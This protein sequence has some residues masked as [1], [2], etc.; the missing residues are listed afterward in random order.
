MRYFYNKFFGVS[1]M[2]D[3][4]E[5]SVDE[6][7]RLQQEAESL[8]A[9]KKENEIQ[10]AYQQVVEIAAKLDLTVE[11]LI[12]QGAQKHKTTSRK[13]VEPRFRNHNNPQDTWTGRGK[14]PRWL[15]A[16]LKKGAKLEDFLI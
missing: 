7:K 15:V 9:S 2:Q 11:Q 8:I 3:I 10:N 14:Q 1:L 5:L 13:K 16:E 4:S 12:E 6:L